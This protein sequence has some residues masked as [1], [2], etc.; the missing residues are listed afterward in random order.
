[1]PG[2]SSFC[3]CCG[4]PAGTQ[5]PAISFFWLL[6]VVITLVIAACCFF[7]LYLTHAASAGAS[8]VLERHEHWGEPGSENGI[9]RNVVSD[10]RLSLRRD[11]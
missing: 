10:Q 1:M 9:H 4:E 6:G 2:K 5:N 11:V 7:L 3:P 8:H